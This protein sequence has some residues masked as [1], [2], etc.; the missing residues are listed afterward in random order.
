MSKTLLL[1]DDSVVIQ[2]LVG[3]SFANED[4]EIVST[5]NGDD[6]VTKARELRPDVVLADVV[7]PGKSGYE[8]CEA[9]KQDAALAHIPVLLLTGTFEAFDESRASAVGADGHITKPFEAQALVE[10]VKNVIKNA[11]PPV[12]ATRPAAQSAPVIPADDLFDD[13]DALLD[14]PPAKPGFFGRTESLDVTPSLSEEDLSDSLDVDLFGPLRWRRRGAELW[15]GSAT[16]LRD[17]SPFLE[18]TVLASSGR[19]ADAPIEDATIAIL[20]EPVAV[21]PPLFRGRTRAERTPSPTISDSM[22]RSR[23]PS[24]RWPP[25]TSIRPSIRRQF[26]RHSSR[27][28]IRH[29]IRQC[30]RRPSRSPSMMRT[31]RPRAASKSLR[32]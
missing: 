14:A 15:R 31:P 6:A 19:F 24:Y 12:A 13:G 29:R 28:C 2:K 1:A 26:S 9:I 7:M 17:G 11:R 4:V 3:L 18:T 27:Q 22:T 10:R 20:A 30:I 23:S 25:S 16:R 21:L 8:V 32:S 5:D